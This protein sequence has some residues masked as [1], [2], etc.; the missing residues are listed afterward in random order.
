MSSN[1]K[2]TVVGFKPL[3][4][5]EFDDPLIQH[6]IKDMF[7]DVVKR[8]DGTIGFKVG[9]TGMYLTEALFSGI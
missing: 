3:I 2:S 9:K 5:R 8:D 7:N 1:I 4:G 6:N